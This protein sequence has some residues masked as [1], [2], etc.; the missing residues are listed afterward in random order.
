MIDKTRTYEKHVVV[1]TAIKYGDSLMPKIYGSVKIRVDRKTVQP[2]I[3]LSSKKG[4]SKKEEK[5]NFSYIFE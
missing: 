5:I 3:S 4:V 2:I 1:Y